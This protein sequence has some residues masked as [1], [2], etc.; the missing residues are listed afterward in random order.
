MLRRGR[1]K[2]VAALALAAALAVPVAPAQAAGLEASGE[3]ARALERLWQW[4]SDVLAP[5]DAA[6]SSLDRGSFI[7][8]NG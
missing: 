4:V 8:P 2:W 1:K 7:D 6:R 5:T 3:L